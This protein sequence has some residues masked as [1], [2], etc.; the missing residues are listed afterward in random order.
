MAKR[1]A[2]A[3]VSALLCASLA[4][5]VTHAEAPVPGAESPRT[6]AS[7]ATQSNA[8]KQEYPPWRRWA[9]ISLVLS[10]L[11]AFALVATTS[12]RWVSRV[13]IPLATPGALPLWTSGMSLITAAPL[14]GRRCDCPTMAR[15]GLTVRGDYTFIKD[16]Q[17][18][19][20]HFAVASV[21]WRRSQRMRLHSR[22]WL[23]ADNQRGRVEAAL[24]LGKSDHG[25]R[26]DDGSRLEVAGAVT[27]H[28]FGPERFATYGVEAFAH[29]RL[30]LKQVSTNM[31][32]T[33]AE[34]TAG[35]G[36]DFLKS[37]GVAMDMSNQ[38]LARTSF[39]IYLHEA[40]GELQ[41]YYDHR[42]DDFAGGFAVRP[43][44]GFVGHVGTSW[45]YFLWD[46]FALAADLEYG[47]AVVARTGIMYRQNGG[48]P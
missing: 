43:A 19:Y 15:T 12:N 28:R 1:V 33:F 13:A 3:V 16:E 24:R 29:G 18:D 11:S 38:L 26:L 45:H 34:L 40:R 32:G 27:M 10:A 5:P 48:K 6:A 23:N 41:L 14:L 8:K 47:S 21:D 7:S 35:I 25:W 17:F 4:T 42:R 30:N 39:G 2:I 46:D 20:K 44:N 31:V 22:W 9:R 37:R 36:F